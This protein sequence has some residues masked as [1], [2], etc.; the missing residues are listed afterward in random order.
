MKPH[1]Y[2]CFIVLAVLLTSATT[3]KEKTHETPKMTIQSQARVS[4]SATLTRKLA[5]SGITV[6]VERATIKNLNT[7]QIAVTNNGGQ[8]TLDL[9]V[10][11]QISISVP[12]NTILDAGGQSSLLVTWTSGQPI[13]KTIVIS[14]TDIAS[15]QAWSGTATLN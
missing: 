10:G 9:S 13:N 4:T 15:N 1:F 12:K 7:G 5:F 8:S 3:K 2:F 11:D 6:P 14:I